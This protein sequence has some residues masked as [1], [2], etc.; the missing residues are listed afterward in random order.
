MPPGSAAST[1]LSVDAVL[2]PPGERVLLEPCWRRVSVVML[3]PPRDASGGSEGME[4]EAGKEETSVRSG[5]KPLAC[6]CHRRE[7]WGCEKQREAAEVGE[8]VV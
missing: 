6:S 2:P 5:V 8:K 3:V 4:E 7:T 1:G